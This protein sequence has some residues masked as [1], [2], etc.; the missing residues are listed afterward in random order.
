MSGSKIRLYGST[1][2]YL[3]LEA[4]AVS[5]DAS[6]VL[7]S[8]F[9]SSIRQIVSATNATNQTTS[10]GSFVDVTGVSVAI[11]PTSD[12]SKILVVCV[13]STYSRRTDQNST[14]S[15]FQLTDGD[16]VALEGAEGVRVGASNVTRVGSSF[17]IYSPLTLVGLAEPA[18]TSAVTYKAR[19]RQG[20]SLAGIVGATNTSKIYAIEVAA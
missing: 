10:S 14:D 6:L 20:A 1:S 4:P 13:L 5:P 19:Y 3:E 8:T 2:G 7:P 12:T 9:A 11:T 18:T 17:D 16:D 15:Y